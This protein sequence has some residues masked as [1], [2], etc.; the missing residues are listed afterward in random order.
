[1]VLNRLR[2]LRPGL[3]VLHF[4]PEWGLV[5]KFSELSG[6]LYT[7]CDLDLTRY[8]SSYTRIYQVDM[9]HDLRKLPCQSFDVIIHNHVLEHVCCSVEDVLTELDRILAYGGQQ[10]F[11]VPIRGEE[12]LE[13][14]SPNL[15]DI[16]RA[17]LFG[18][19]DHVRIFG[20][21]DI[22][23]L[24]R[25][26]WGSD[27][28]Y[29]FP[30]DWFS[31]EQLEAIGLPSDSW[32]KLDYNTIFY[33]VKS[34]TVSWAS[35][36]L[37]NNGKS[38]TKEHAISIIQPSSLYNLGKAWGCNSVNCTPFRSKGLFTHA[39]IQFGGF[40]DPSGDAVF[41]ARDLKDNRLRWGKIPNSKKPFDAHNIISMAADR[42]GRL[43]VALGGHIS[44]MIYARSV[45][46]YSVEQF[47]IKP[48]DEQRE[49]DEKLTYPTFVSLRN[50]DLLLLHR[51]GGLPGGDLSIKRYDIDKD[52]WI[53]DSLP[54]LTGPLNQPGGATPYINVP[55][56]GEDGCVGLFY[57][58]RLLRGAGP[59]ERVINAG[60][61]YAESHD[62]LQTLETIG[63][64]S[65]ARPVTPQT[66][67]TVHAVPFD[68]NLINQT[69]ACF[70]RQGWPVYA[71]YW[72]DLDGVPQIGIIFYTG[73]TWR[74]QQSYCNTTRF[75]LSGRGT[76]PIPLSRPIVVCDKDDCLYLL[77]R[78]HEHSG[79]LMAY[80]LFPPDYAFETGGFCKLWNE[81]LGYY[82]PVIDTSALVERGVLSL[83][84]QFCGFR[85]DGHAGNPA[86]AEAI[87]AEWPL[88]AIKGNPAVNFSLICSKH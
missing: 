6:E 83:Y 33:R 19:H 37:H 84:L 23:N 76:L 50:G 18:Q 15:T 77:F 43:H 71:G 2:L 31:K 16:D 58:W 70:T 26:V 44:K 60:V 80:I 48:L 42:T 54:L 73:R 30:T 87:V 52:C 55:V 63:G 4:A 7:P 32:S 79:A 46:P 17:R 51:V 59:E 13:D 27:Q 40:Y 88:Q 49:D 8:K 41:F 24:L 3:R 67:E 57:V 39:G 45:E 61:Y 36:R 21:R 65:L 75:H 9:C 25:K 22:L 29:I 11:S 78:S 68:G 82:E 69:G 86:P 47:E 10:F 14:L 74:V 53:A 81:D 62:G 5:K 35:S 1:M 34:Q 38:E 20:Q 66:S 56:V 72:N 28:P 85:A 12:T 64:F